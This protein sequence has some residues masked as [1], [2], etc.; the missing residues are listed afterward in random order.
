MAKI[1]FISKGYAGRSTNWESHRSVNFYPEL[2]SDAE[3]KS[4]VALIG[5]PGLGPFGAVGTAAIRGI[6][7]FAG[8]IFVVSAGGLY[9]IGLYGD[10][11]PVPLGTLQTSSGRVSMADNGQKSAGIGGDQ[12]MIVDGVAGYVYNVTTKVFSVVASISAIPAIATLTTTP[13]TIASVAVTSMGSGYTSA[14]TAAITDSTGSGA[15]LQVNIGHPIKSITMGMPSPGGII[16]TGDPVITITD[17]TGTGATATADKFVGNLVTG[18]TMTNHGTGYTNPTVTVTNIPGIVVTPNLDTG[19][20]NPIS[21]KVVTPGT[22][23]TSPIVV[24]SGGGGSG[25]SALAK[26]SIK[27]ITSINLISGGSGYISDPVVTI[28]GTNG[29]TQATATVAN[30]TITGI[31]IVS[32]GTGYSDIPTISISAPEGSNFPASPQQVTYMDGYF[33]LT[34]GTMSHYVSNLYNGLLWNPIA[35]SPVSGTTDNIQTPFN[36]HQQLWFIKQFATEVWYDSGTATSEGSPFSRVSGAIIDYGTPAPWS[37]T[38]GSNSIFFLASQRTESGGAFIG[39]VELSGYSPAVIS[40]PAITYQMSLWRDMANAF[41]F[42]YSEG[43]HTFIVFTSPGDNQ[44]LVYDTTTQSWHEW[45]SYTAQPYVTGRHLANCYAYFNGKHLVG[46]YQ[47]GNI[48]ELSSSFYTENG[49]PIVS[50]QTTPIL[51]DKNDRNNIFISRLTIDAEIGIGS[52]SGSDPQASLSWSNDSGHTWS[53][54]YPASMGKIGEYRKRLVW[55]RLGYARDRVF[56]VAIDAPV[57]KVLIAAYV[58]AS[59]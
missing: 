2:A 35:T 58:E 27:T 19:N 11:S 36:F 33:I 17:P 56:R 3:S 44:T 46:D 20:F 23:Y 8:L 49:N 30:T 1:P 12:L 59:E 39:A 37:V 40:P 4:V 21:I 15:T 22:N 50:F 51:S 18:I 32:G 53:N 5:T 52:E 54:D 31:Q 14:P 7:V 25:A 16:A 6:H 45:S 24:F 38:R 43:G 13:S 48:Y 28:S 9:S 57:K 10:I 42:S 34:N 26:T 29:A 47:T 55:R 41:A